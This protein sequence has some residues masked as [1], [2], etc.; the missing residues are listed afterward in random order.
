VETADQADRDLLDGGQQ[1][2]PEKDAK[3]AKG[4]DRV[5]VSKSQSVSK[6][7]RRKADQLPLF[8]ESTSSEK[9]AVGR[10]G[11]P[12]TNKPKRARGAGKQ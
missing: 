9:K 10:A 3:N 1:R 7:S 4:A 5:P 12:G 8:A 6:K 11:S 2:K